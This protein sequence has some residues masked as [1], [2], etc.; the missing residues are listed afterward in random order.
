MELSLIVLRCRDVARSRALY[1][2]VGCRFVE[3]AHG[4]G[5]L[6]LAHEQ[7]GFV[8][9]LYPAPEGYADRTGVG[10]TVDDLE[11]VRAATAAAG[12][13]PA[14]ITATAW[15]DSFVVRDPDGRRVE[16]KRRGG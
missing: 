4:G 16:V 8:L 11:G 7:E 6:H 15:G 12:F 5:P 2:A 1:E 3:H 14:G 9:E 10:F 13:A